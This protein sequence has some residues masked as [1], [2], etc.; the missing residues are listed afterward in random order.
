MKPQAS[1]QLLL[2]AKHFPPGRA[3]EMLRPVIFMLRHI[4]LHPVQLTPA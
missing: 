4:E 3:A 1:L 2:K